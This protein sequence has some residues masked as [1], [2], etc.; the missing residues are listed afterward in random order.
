MKIKSL[1]LILFVSIFSCQKESSLDESKFRVWLNPDVKLEDVLT[2]KISLKVGYDDQ[3]KIYY[4]ED[5]TEN[6]N[7]EKTVKTKVK[8]AKTEQIVIFKFPKHVNPTNLRFDFGFNQKQVDFQINKFEFIYKGSYF[9]VQGEVLL[10]YFKIFDNR[11]IFDSSSKLL[12]VNKKVKRKQYHPTIISKENFKIELNSL[13]KSEEENNRI[14]KFSSEQLTSLTSTKLIKSSI[15]NF[16][17][18]NNYL[19][20]KGWVILDH[21]NSKNTITKVLFVKDNTGYVVETTK[22]R[23]EDV[24]KFFK[25]NYNA[26]FS[27][28]EKEGYLNF[29]PSGKYKLALWL[30]N[31]TEQKEGLLITKKEISI[32]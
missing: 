15:E 27:G 29:I 22:K 17:F 7:E 24:T 5:N 20:L 26:D 2:V 12:K 25:L 14:V 6:F 19:K 18:N 16:E 1:L 28:F 32:Q 3:F 31:E 30:K 8:G 10:D 21:A 13:L 4:S 9:R 11:L 23:R